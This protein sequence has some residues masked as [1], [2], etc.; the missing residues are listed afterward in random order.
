MLNTFKNIKDIQSRLTSGYKPL[1]IL[2]LL[3]IIS[4]GSSKAQ[5]LL[6]N[7][8]FEDYTTCP[9]GYTDPF[10][11]PNY[12]INKCIGWTKPT[13]GTSD[14][15]NQCANG[16]LVGITTTTL[17]YQQPYSGDGYLG[18]FFISL[19]GGEGTDGYNGI[20]WWEYIQGQFI[21]PLE[22]NKTY[23]ISF[24]ISLAEYSDLALKEFGAYISVNAISSPNSANLTV[25]PQLKFVAPAYYSDTANWVSVSGTYL[26][27][28][29]EKYITIGNF[30]SDVD[31]NTVRLR[32]DNPPDNVSYYWIDAGEV[33][34]ISGEPFIPNII[35]P[36]NDGMND[37]F[38]LNFPFLKAEIYNRWGQR[39]FEAKENGTYWD[40][41]TTAGKQVP[42]GTYYYIIT[43]KEKV[44]TGFLQLLK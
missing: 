36:N 7:G 34:D 32:M 26:A 4:V 22:A 8:D 15:F 21:T 42:D 24:K 18:A 23:Q 38:Q 10:Q 37:L 35:T 43:T 6:L 28:G 31:M 29:G 13:Y 12:E 5:N 44:Y 14:Y 27:S 39:L 2:I 11:A 19:Q 17:G 1:Y 40:G 20:M 30:K 16:N 25:T 9:T 41:R 33:I 3:L